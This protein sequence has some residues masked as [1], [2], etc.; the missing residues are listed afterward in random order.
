MTIR[1]IIEQENPINK[2]YQQ[3]VLICN[4]FRLECKMCSIIYAARFFWRT[5]RS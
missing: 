3:A 5:Q 4:L 1:Q 2:I